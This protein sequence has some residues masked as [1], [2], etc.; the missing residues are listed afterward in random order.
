M[1]QVALTAT[2]F[3]AS[4]ALRFQLQAVN[5]R[6]W[7]PRGK[8]PFQ[9]EWNRHDRLSIVAGLIYRPRSKRISLTFAVH[10]HNIRAPDFHDFLLQLRREIRRPIVLV[11]DRYSVHRSADRRLKN[12]HADWLRVAWP[13]SYA[14]D[15]NPVEAAW[16]HAKYCDLPNYAPK[17]AYELANRVAE[18]INDQQF[19]P[20]LLQSFFRRAQLRDSESWLRREQ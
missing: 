2:S 14:P 3:A 12:W 17:D 15:L 9:Y 20:T 18:S 10:D 19:R 5:R 13:P 1:G 16:D 8:T 4:A 7:T 6:T 11:C